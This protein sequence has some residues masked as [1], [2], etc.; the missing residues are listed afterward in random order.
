M[1]IMV[2]CYQIQFS[3]YPKDPILSEGTAN[4]AVKGLLFSIDMVA[5]GK[6][7]RFFA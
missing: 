6:K 4:T 1:V 7:G 3:C 2:I 5:T